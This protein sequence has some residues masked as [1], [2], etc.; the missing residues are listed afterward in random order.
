MSYTFSFIRSL[1]FICSKI[2]I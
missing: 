1:I 2:S